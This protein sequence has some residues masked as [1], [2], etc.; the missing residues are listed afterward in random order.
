MDGTLIIGYGNPLRGDD[1]VGFLAAE[2]LSRT[3]AD[4]GVTVLAVHQITPEL[5]EPVSRARRVIFMDASVGAER[6]QIRERPIRPP[7]PSPSSPMSP[8]L[9]PLRTTLRPKPF[10]PPRSRFTGEPP[11]RG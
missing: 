2:R 8:R 6:G 1:A 10:W 7:V 3:I 4:P 5:A 11:R 9:P